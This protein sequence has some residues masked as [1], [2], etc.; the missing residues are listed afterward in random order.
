MSTSTRKKRVEFWKA[1][2]RASECPRGT[3]GSMGLVS[4]VDPRSHIRLTAVGRD[5]GRVNGDNCSRLSARDAPLHA[6]WWSAVLIA[7]PT[8]RC[9]H[10]VPCSGHPETGPGVGHSALCVQF[11]SGGGALGMQARR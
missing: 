5:G 2:S 8:S 11:D 1:S 7:T 4:N 6:D 3:P 9:G 10:Q